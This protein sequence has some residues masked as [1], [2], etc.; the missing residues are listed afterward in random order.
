[1]KHA[2]SLACQ[3]FQ[4]ARSEIFFPELDVIHSGLRGFGDFGEQ[5]ASAGGF[6]ATELRPVGDVVEQTA[7][8]HQEPAY[9]GGSQ[10][11]EHTR[12]RARAA[13]TA[14]FWRFRARRL[15]RCVS[16]VAVRGGIW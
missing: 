12:A 14:W 10:A 13:L 8:S 9:Y 2:N 1:M 5:S 15:H 3:S 6:V 4:F 7:G 16:A 11:Y